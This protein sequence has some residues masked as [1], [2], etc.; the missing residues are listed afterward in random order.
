MNLLAHLWLAEYT[1][2]SAA[3]QLLGDLVKGRLN[4]S[5]LDSYSCQGIRLHRLIDSVSDAHPAHIALR[6]CFAPPLRRYAG[7]LVDIGLDHALA[8]HWSDYCQQDLSAFAWRINRRVV[9]EWPSGLG[10]THP[11]Y[12]GLAQLLV[13]Y[14][15]ADG[16][17]HALN[18]VGRRARRTNPLA[19]A[20]PALQSLSADFAQAL[21][22]LLTSLQSQA[23]QFA[24]DTRA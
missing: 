11:A 6:R 17:Q 7:I 10:Y 22:A 21:P 13:S 14:S 23:Q 9:R 20:L 15:H 1:H 12:P 18:S 3:G 8:R 24:H 19:Q 2:T 5:P 16:I 4:H